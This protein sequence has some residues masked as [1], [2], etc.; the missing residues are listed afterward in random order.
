MTLHQLSATWV[1]AN[2]RF[3]SRSSDWM[4]IGVIAAVILH[5][6]VFALFPELHAAEIDTPADAALAIE[7][8]PPVEIPPPPE[9][10]VRPATPRASDVPLDEPFAIPRQDDA[11]HALPAPPPGAGARPG[12][13]GRWVPRDVE[14][15]LKNGSELIRQLAQ[16]YPPQLRE[17]GIEATVRIHM[18][19]SPEGKVEKAAIETSSGYPAFD[20]AA[21]EASG[22]AEFSPALSRDRPV[23]VWILLPM[24]FRLH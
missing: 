1:S 6:G 19:V 15:R 11:F 24:K 14:P 23:G 5:A 22:D 18:F 20:R 13:V 2:D 10:I 3:K 21:L 9:N 12:E 17:A 4:S 7:L 16:R 8:P